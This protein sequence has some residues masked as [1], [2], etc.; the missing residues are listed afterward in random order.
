MNFAGCGILLD[1]EGT[2]SSV[3]YVF[4]VM[5][6]YVRWHLHPFLSAHWLDDEVVAAARLMA[7]D[8]GHTDLAQLCPA[9][10]RQTRQ[11]A[12][13][14]HVI[15]LMDQDAKATGLKEL[16]GII[17][18]DGF[19]RGE[20]RAHVYADVPPALHRWH[21]CGLQ[22]G[23]YSSGSITAQKL[24][25]GH[26]EAG[27]LLPLLLRHYDTTIGAK[28]DPLSYR[29]IVADIGDPPENL[30]FISDIV[31]E[32]DAAREAGLQTALCLRPENSPVAAGHGHS[33]IESFEEVCATWKAI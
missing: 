16:Q 22:L 6:P 28:R 29:R 31:A 25:F 19:T 27:D 18:R 15:E 12:L 5:F 24:F 33:V 26:T 7:L 9:P 3:R 21:E 13:E 2:T 30:L 10:D 20:L 23:I 4:D 8:A 17:W 1:I 14:M 32:L 11:R